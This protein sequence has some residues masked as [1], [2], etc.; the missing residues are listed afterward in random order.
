[1][2]AKTANSK[3]LDIIGNGDHSSAQ[4]VL[5][6]T[7]KRWRQRLG[8][9]S[10]F[11][12]VPAIF[13]WNLPV[14]HSD[15]SKK[16]KANAVEPT[17][18]RLRRL[19]NGVS[20]RALLKRQASFRLPHQKGNFA[21]T[22]A[23]AG[24]DD[25][26]GRVITGGNYTA[27]APYIDSGDTTGANDTV[28]RV[29]GYYYYYE[30]NGPDHIY[31][32]TLTG[33]GPNPR[34]EVSTTSGTYK[35]MIY[36]L[37]GEPHGV[38]PAGTGNLAFNNLVTY[39]S[40]WNRDGSSTAT[41]HINW[42][43]L[44]VPFHLFVDSAFNDAFGAGPYTIKMQ[45][46]T[47][48]PEEVPCTQPNPIDCERFFVR[49]QYVDF[50][51]RSPEPSC[52][53]NKCG[54]DFYVPILNGCGTDV[55]CMKYT[56]AVLSANFF[57]SPEF[58][59]KGAF[60]ANLYN[61]SFGQR[62][63]TVAELGDPAKVERPHY[64][65]FRS[66]LAFITAPTASETNLKKDQLAAGF[67]Q[68]AG[69]AQILPGSLTNQQF[70]Q[71]LESIAGVTLANESALIASLNAGTPRYLVFREVAESPEVTAKFYKPNFVMMEY[72][73]Y[74]RRDPEDCHNSAN[75]PGGDP[76]NCGYIFHNSRFNLSSDADAI[77]NVIVRGF[78]ESPEYRHRFGP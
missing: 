58:Q 33:L 66:E 50:L 55:E 47:I 36:I 67:F 75:W 1:M 22:A 57:R 62:P 21:I 20:N 13:A 68:K 65:E 77:E 2:N 35:P 17:P 28:R 7:L 51:N 11:A 4:E 29:L 37:Q 39:D 12:A 56:R 52:P 60:V 71:K 45:D 63:K 19:N 76:N 24:N 25:C 64:A 23:L 5:T 32:F 49:Q 34:I 10:I 61:I 42:L 14:A 74:L 6:A 54:L 59:Q 9:C 72:F 38:C 41:V 46:V 78:I 44:N 31:S 3:R 26:P 18:E 15:E 73:G 48:N 43:P 53:P 69:F 8:Y 70:V 27:A 40:R 16:P 30:S